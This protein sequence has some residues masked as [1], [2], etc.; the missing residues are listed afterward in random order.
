MLQPEAQHNAVR[1]YIEAK[2]MRLLGPQVPDPR[3]SPQRESVTESLSL[4][5]PDLQSSAARTAAAYSFQIRIQEKLI[6]RH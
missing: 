3:P 1:E 5:V 2:A 6:A 4:N